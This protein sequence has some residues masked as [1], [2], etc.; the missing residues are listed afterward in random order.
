[1]EVG[2]GGGRGMDGC[3]NLEVVYISCVGQG[4]V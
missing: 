4:K 1:M 2:F 3:E